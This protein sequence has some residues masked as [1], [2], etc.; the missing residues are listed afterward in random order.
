MNSQLGTSATPFS[1]RRLLD[2]P[3][4]DHQNYQTYVLS[5]LRYEGLAKFLCEH[6]K[7]SPRLRALDIGCGAGVISRGLANDFEQVTGV[8]G[9][10]DNVV[11][12]QSITQDAGVSNVT[13][14]HADATRLPVEDESLDLVVLNGVLEWVGVN[15]AG[16]NPRARQL[17]VLREV[18]RVL[19]Q[20][21]FLYLAIE[22]RWHPRT[23]LKDPHSGLPMVNGLPRML[24]NQLSKGMS[25]KPF[26]T[27]IYGW[28][29]L[30]KLLSH[31]GLGDAELFLPFPG[32]Q[33]PMSYI[34]AQPRKR[35]LDDI[36]QI[37]VP[38]VQKVLDEA[39]RPTDV[40]EAVRTMRRRAERGLIASLSHDLVFL[41]RR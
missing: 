22:N 2:Q 13:Y 24:A 26:Q 21:G 8:D 18:R 3:D 17:R 5:G 35:T 20:G 23:I 16:E 28:R 1:F 4:G 40:E 11:L 30:R 27:Y 9:N 37:D 32:Y 38:R 12:A 10:Q 29:R 33:Y 25:G 31:V 6:L 19:R 7:H 41:C 39:G 15:E 14:Q 34:A 36:A